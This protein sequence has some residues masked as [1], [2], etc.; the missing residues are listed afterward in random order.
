MTEKSNKPRNTEVLPPK[1]AKE[2]EKEI[3]IEGLEKVESVLSVSMAGP[4]PIS[5]EFA[6]YDNILPGAAREILD[7]AKNEQSHRHGLDRR[8]MNWGILHQFSTLLLGVSLLIL[9]ILGAIYLTLK[10]HPI[11]AGLIVG[12]AVLG[13]VTS[14]IKRDPSFTGRGDN[15][16]EAK[17]SE[18]E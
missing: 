2:L 8:D 12:V 3:G 13:V 16:S 14:V 10:G 15:N 4:L 6:A 11:M 7:M 1:A 5:S 17:N 9:C 18:I